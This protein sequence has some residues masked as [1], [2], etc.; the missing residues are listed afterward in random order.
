MSY[1][2]KTAWN[3]I[4]ESLTGKLFIETGSRKMIEV[5]RTDCNGNMSVE[6]CFIDQ[7]IPQ[8]IHGT[9][10]LSD[11]ATKSYVEVTREEWNNHLRGNHIN[12]TQLLEEFAKS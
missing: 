4:N 11:L 5:L 2:R 9:V 1:E 6:Y 12:T 3:Y 7:A 8:Q 10:S